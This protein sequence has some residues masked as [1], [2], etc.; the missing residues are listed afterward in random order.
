M[1]RRSPRLGGSCVRFL[2]S[3]CQINPRPAPFSCPRPLIPF[4]AWSRY[5]SGRLNQSHQLLPLRIQRPAQE[6]QPADDGPPMERQ[7]QPGIAPRRLL[8]IFPLCKAVYVFRRRSMTLPE[9]ISHIQSRGG[10]FCPKAPARPSADAA[11]PQARIA[12]LFGQNKKPSASLL[13]RRT[14][15]CVKLRC[16][17]RLVSLSGPGG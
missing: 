3:L 11:A 16:R 17:P 10:E 9:A 12:E 8:Q 7:H 4:P 15:C 14:V 1:R 5:K 6:A 2:F 13:E